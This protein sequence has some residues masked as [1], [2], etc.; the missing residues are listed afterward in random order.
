MDFTLNQV[1]NHAPLF[2]AFGPDRDMIYCLPREIGLF[3]AA[4]GSY[5]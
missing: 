3:E 1:A 2:C 5:F 4:A